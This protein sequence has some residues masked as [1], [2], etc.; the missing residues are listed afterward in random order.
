MGSGP[1]THARVRIINTNSFL[2]D[3]DLHMGKRVESSPT[4][5]E[6]GIQ[7]GIQLGPSVRS[8]M[9]CTAT[10]TDEENPYTLHRWCAPRVLGK[11]KALIGDRIRLL[12][13][14]GGEGW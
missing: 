1:I 6:L 11:H 4:H 13:V 12:K 5:P 2:S 8:L 3:H 7:N 10:T 9:E 14:R